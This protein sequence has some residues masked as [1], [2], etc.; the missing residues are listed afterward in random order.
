MALAW[1]RMWKHLNDTS[2]FSFCHYLIWNW[3]SRLIAP[4]MTSAWLDKAK[5]RV[6]SVPGNLGSQQTM[7]FTLTMLEALITYI[8]PFISCSQINDY[9]GYFRTWVP[10]EYT[11]FLPSVI[12][13][14]FCFRFPFFFFFPLRTIPV[15]FVCLVGCLVVCLFVFCLNN[16]IQHDLRCSKHHRDLCDW[17][18]F[19][20]KVL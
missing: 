13:N 15:P 1:F 20:K 9:L 5:I 12:M 6:S 19:G 17:S 18:I 3:N 11:G 16:S 4:L 7:N 2:H 10:Q 8:F 14:I